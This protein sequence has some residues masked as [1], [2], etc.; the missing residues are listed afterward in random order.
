MSPELKPGQLTVFRRSSGHWP[1]GCIVL[2]DTPSGEVVKFAARVGSDIHLY[3]SATDS[4]SYTVDGDSV[5]AVL[6]WP[7]R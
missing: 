1:S 3:G 2:A 5:R 4:S 6:V 7:L